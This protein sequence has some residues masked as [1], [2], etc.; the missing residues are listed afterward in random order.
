MPIP[1]PAFVC[2]PTSEQAARPQDLVKPDDLTWQGLPAYATASMPASRRQPHGPVPL[3][4]VFAGW[5]SRCPRTNERLWDAGNKRCPASRKRN[6]ASAV[7]GAERHHLSGRS[8]G[9]GWQDYP[10]ITILS[11]SIRAGAADAPWQI[12]LHRSA[13]RLGQRATAFHGA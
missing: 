6:G 1:S 7:T 5:G 10:W 2:L 11:V 4:R 12:C 13:R 8:A 9:A 3:R